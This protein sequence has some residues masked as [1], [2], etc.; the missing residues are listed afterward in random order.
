[1]CQ[2]C[3][4][5]RRQVDFAARLGRDRLTLD[6]LLAVMEPAPGG[7]RNG[8]SIVVPGG[9]KSAE[10]FLSSAVVTDVDEFGRTVAAPRVEENKT[11]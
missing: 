9:A 11:D 10:E 3:D 4:F 7:W 2:D 5:H 6:D 1:M 8:F